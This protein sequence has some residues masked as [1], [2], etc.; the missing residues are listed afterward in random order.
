MKSRSKERRRYNSIGIPSEIKEGFDAVL[1]YLA[2]R[3]GQLFPYGSYRILAA[4]LLLAIGPDEWKRI[5]GAQD[6]QTLLT[7]CVREYGALER[8]IEIEAE[9]GD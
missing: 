6:R 5:K 3:D 2:K 4:A 8:S 1:L 7:E 9:G